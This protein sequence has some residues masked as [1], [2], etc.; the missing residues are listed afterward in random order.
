[1][2]IIISF[3]LNKNQTTYSLFLCTIPFSSS[4]YTCFDK[5]QTKGVIFIH[6]KYQS[7]YITLYYCKCLPST[8]KV[9]NLY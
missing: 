2:L 9:F 6:P 1:M 8:I 4:N 7:D 5:I 3:L